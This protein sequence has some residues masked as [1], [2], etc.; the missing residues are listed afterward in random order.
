MPLPDTIKA[1]LPTLQ[2]PRRCGLVVGLV[3]AALLVGELGGWSSAGRLVAVAALPMLFQPSPGSLAGWRPGRDALHA[4]AAGLVVA[5]L[6]HWVWAPGLLS[7]GETTGSDLAEWFWTLHSLSNPGWQHFSVNRY[8]LAPLLARMLAFAGNPH[9]AWL[10]AAVVSAG[11]TAAGL[12][13][14]GRALAGVAAGW[15]AALMVGALPDLVVMSRNVTGYPEIIAIWTV[16]AGLAA[17]ALRHPTLPTC[18]LAGLG[19]GACFAVDPRGLIPGVLVTLVAITGGLSARGRWRRLLCLGMVLAPLYGSWL[20]HNQLPLQPRSLEELLVTS[21]R[22]S[23][24]RTGQQSPWVRHEAGAWIWG[25]STLLDL[26]TTVGNMRE[27]RSHLNPAVA[28]SA[29]QRRAVSRNV[30]PLAMVL[31]VASLLALLTLRRHPPPNTFSW[32][33][34]HHQ[35]DW[36]AALALLP[37]AAHLTWFSNVVRYEY[38]PRYFALAMPGAALLLGLGIAAMAGRRRPPWLPVAVALALLFVIPSVLNTRAAWRP[39]GAAERELQQCLAV[40]R[41]DESLPP[42]EGGAYKSPVEECVAAQ[43]KPLEPPRWPW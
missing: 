9:D 3:I 21:V 28:S 43:S 37:L 40:A 41:G 23:Y 17:Y 30:Q 8:P 11:F 36:R 13:L 7:E 18:L 33:G 12:W 29:E 16:A 4:V 22:V 25:R 2:H 14:W 24:E 20:V 10:A 1:Q 15:T 26:P 27:A 5:A 31:A 19:S 6:C 35:L 38:H 39:R 32:R 34:L 42:S